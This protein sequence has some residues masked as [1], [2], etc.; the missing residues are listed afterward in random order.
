MPMSC[1]IVGVD[2]EAIDR[3]HENL[4][5]PQLTRTHPASKGSAERHSVSNEFM[6]AE[7]PELSIIIAISS[8]PG[9]ENASAAV[10]GPQ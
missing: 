7:I 9:G 5:T 3:R 10:A 4:L 1:E 6:L 8:A 2:G